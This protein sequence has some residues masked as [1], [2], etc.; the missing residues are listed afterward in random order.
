[1]V[2]LRDPV[3]AG[4]LAEGPAT[5]ADGETVVKTRAHERKPV[6]DRD[7]ITNAL[8]ANRPYESSAL[9]MGVDFNHHRLPP[10]RAGGGI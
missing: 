9:M 10:I 5:F 8:R 1:M 3:A 4:E 6:A 7:G 2:R